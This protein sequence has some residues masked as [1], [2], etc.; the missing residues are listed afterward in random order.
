MADDD[1]KSPVDPPADP[2]PAPAAPADPE[3]APTSEH[4]PTAL[5]ALQETVTGL[6]A[7]VASLTDVVSKTIRPDENPVNSVPWTHFGSKPV[8]HGGDDS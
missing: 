4:E 1:D 7:S 5:A 3:P 8:H 6:V 2:E